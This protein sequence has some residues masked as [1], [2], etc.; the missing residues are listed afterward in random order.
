MS[1]RRV[2]VT[3]RCLTDD[4]GIPLPRTDTDIGELDHPLLEECRRLAELAPR[5]QKR[6]LSI[7]HPLV[8]RVSHGRWRGASWVDEDHKFFWLLA[9]EQ[10]EEGSL[11]DAYIH[12]E[13]LHDSNKLLPTRDDYLRDRVEEGS[14]VLAAI[15]TE[16]PQAIA[17]ARERPGADHSVLLLDRVE[18]VVHVQR[19]DGIEMIWMAVSAMDPEAKV[20]NVRLRDLIFVVAEQ[21]LG[22]AEWE[23]TTDWPIERELKWFEV[24]RLALREVS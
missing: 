6:I 9:A 5:G 12:F 21:T 2:R 18:V 16:L 14:R 20:V 15:K 17:Q 24:A 7:D 1:P 11:D 10:R 13:S 8:Y 23:W 19:D 3:I 22:G 4:L